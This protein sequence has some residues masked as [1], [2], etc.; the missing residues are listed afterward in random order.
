MDAPTYHICANRVYSHKMCYDLLGSKE[1]PPKKL[2]CAK[3]WSTSVKVVRKHSVTFTPLEHV[4]REWV[5]EA[6]RN[7]W[8][9]MEIREEVLG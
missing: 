6:C 8:R 9:T 1:S 5:C 3:C 4:R 2:A 7:T